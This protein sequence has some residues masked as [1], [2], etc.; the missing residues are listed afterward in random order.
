MP[1]T[2]ELGLGTP[3]EDQLAHFRAKLNLPTEAWDDVMRSAHDRAFVVAGAMK[4]DLLQDLRTAMDKAM[5]GGGQAQF[6]R[7]FRE[8][9]ARHGWEGWTGEGSAQGEA[10]RARTIYR[11]NMASS[12]AAGRYKQLTEPDFLRANPYWRYRH[13]DGVTHPRPL[14]LA[15]HNLCLPATHEFWRTHFAPN[16]WGC[17]CKVFAEPAPPP[18]AKLEPPAGWDSINPS[19]GAQ[20]GIDRGW[21]YTPGQADATPWLD[22]VNQKLL[23]LD[24][25]IGAAMAEV[26]EPAIVQDRRRAWSNAVERVFTEKRA[27]NETFAVGSLRP[28]V[29]AELAKVGVTPDTASIMIRDAEMLHA[30]RALKEARQAAVPEDLWRQLPD[31]LKTA[32]VYLDTED[33]TALMF[34]VDYPPRLAKFVIR[35]NMSLKTRLDGVRETLVANFIQTAGLLPPGNIRGDA[36]YLRLP[37]E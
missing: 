2:M 23:N 22:L 20:V 35:V 34:V 5:A 36:K 1:A 11:T 18:G 27:T 10:W 29:V 8:I 32:E 24:A 37:E 33:K 3:F 25:P 12:Y 6:T 21:D 16:G 26:L 28:S 31:L 17:N 15:W 13:A 14:H 7:D 19:T 30:I 4:A 9:V